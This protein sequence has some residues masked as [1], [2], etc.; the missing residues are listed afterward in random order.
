MITVYLL[1]STYVDQVAKDSVVNLIRGSNA[2]VFW[3][4]II[5]CGLIVPIIASVIS[6]FAT[7]A[8]IGIL[9][10]A[11]FCEV[12]GGFSL[13]Y[14]ILREGIYKPLIHTNL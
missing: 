7:D 3:G 5:F 6:F 14:A 1:E 4:G 11:V 8:S 9:I 2:L 10:L 12:I 13:R